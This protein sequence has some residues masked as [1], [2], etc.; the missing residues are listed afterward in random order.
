MA[1]D[2]YV[3]RLI[4]RDGHVLKSIQDESR[5]RI[6]ISSANEVNQFNGDR[7]IAIYGSI[8]AISKAEAMISEKL[9]RVF[10]QEHKK[11]EYS[12]ACKTSNSKILLLPHRNNFFSI[13]C[14]LDLS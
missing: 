9:V 7:Q 6:A 10:I 1:D 2:R 14:A 11:P 13:F 4:G 12:K 5:A 8:E 3:G